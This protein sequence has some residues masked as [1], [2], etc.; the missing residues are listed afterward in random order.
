MHD[1][2]I[3][4]R[5]RSTSQTLANMSRR[6]LRVGSAVLVSASVLLVLT[7]MPLTRAVASIRLLNVSQPFS[8]SVLNATIDAATTVRAFILDQDGES[9]H[10]ASF[11]LSDDSRFSRSSWDCGAWGAQGAVIAQKVLALGAG[12]RTVSVTH[13]SGSSS[14]NSSGGSR[15]DSN[16][17]HNDRQSTEDKSVDFLRLVRRWLLNTPQYSSTGEVFAT[18]GGR[19]HM[20]NDGKWEANAEFILSAALFAK[21]AGSGGGVFDASVERLVCTVDSVTGR[22]SLVA[23]GDGTSTLGDSVCFAIPSADWEL[24][25]HPG[26][27]GTT[28]NGAYIGHTEG[29]TA[30]PCPGTALYQN[31]ELPEPASALALP[32]RLYS[33]LPPG[34][35]AWTLTAKVFAIN[36]TKDILRPQNLSSNGGKRK[37][38]ED[39]LLFSQDINVTAAAWVDLVPPDKGC[40]S[41]GLYRIELWPSATHLP[42]RGGID[43]SLFTSAAWTSSILPSPLPRNHSVRGGGGTMLFWIGP[44]ADSHAN[45]VEGVEQILGA[46]LRKAAQWQLQFATAPNSTLQGDSRFGIATLT[47]PQWRG[48]G[49]DDVGAASAMWDL[50]RS[51]YKDSYLNARMIESFEA[52]LQ[53]QDAGLIPGEPIVTRPIVNSIRES[54]VQTFSTPDD[55]NGY[56]RSSTA[57]AHGEFVSWIGCRQSVAAANHS[58]ACDLSNQEI[59]DIGFV[60]SLAIAASLGLSSSNSANRSVAV[61]AFDA[62]RDTARTGFGRFR[63]NIKPI[64]AVDVKLWRPSSQ[65]TKPTTDGFARKE[66]DS[67]GDWQIFDP[68]Q[69]Q[70]CSLVHN[71]T[72]LP[73]ELFSL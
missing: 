12:G 45:N 67:G 15:S 1:V 48:V 31:V 46:R 10:K 36:E 47:E 52:M 11:A 25:T 57:A 14:G 18:E 22:R 33:R 21:H 42:P 27:F 72:R 40:L 68:L 55:S 19:L 49:A 53:M 64:E 54:F 37:P 4:H 61:A 50:I 32:L 20:G 58:G 39:K 34:T 60:P 23:G 28:M 63:T 43:Q 30:I 41:A 69:F 2:H 73:M 3:L 13:S 7:L 44:N 26:L 16:D 5:Y 8:S 29:P 17:N 59:V 56:L 51:G 66:A 9:T 6:P 62:V 65:W 38:L 35:S 71:E 24:A 70:G